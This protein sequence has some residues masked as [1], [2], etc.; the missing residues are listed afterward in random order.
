MARV[1]PK[2]ENASQLD[3]ASSVHGLLSMQS[4]YYIVYILTMYLPYLPAIVASI[5][6]GVAS[7]N[8]LALAMYLISL[9]LSLLA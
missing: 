8:P 2:N 5:T 7:N 6:G 4:C 1:I 3:L 9:G